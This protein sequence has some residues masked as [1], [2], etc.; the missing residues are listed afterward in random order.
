MSNEP[1]NLPPGSEVQVDGSLWTK[2]F[3]GA[4]SERAIKTFAQALA[5][6]L[7]AGAVGILETTWIPILSLAG[8]QFILS[9]LTSVGSGIITHSGPSLAPGEVVVARRALPGYADE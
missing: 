9:I 5:G 4:A 7:V 1:V 3:W 2:Q 8:M 6:L